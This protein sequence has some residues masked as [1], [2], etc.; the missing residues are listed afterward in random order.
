MYKIVSDLFF[1][2]HNSATI[3]QEAAIREKIGL[4]VESLE[5]DCLSETCK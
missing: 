4:E 1:Q 5:L 2:I 3:P